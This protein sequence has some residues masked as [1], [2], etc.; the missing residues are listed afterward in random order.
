MQTEACVYGDG[1]QREKR[2]QPEITMIFMLNQA[3]HVVTARQQSW[4]DFSTDMLIK[5]F[6]HFGLIINP[7]QLT[8]LISLWP[9]I[10]DKYMPNRVPQTRLR[11]I[12]PNTIEYIM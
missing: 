4:T 7:V 8:A 3:L 6:G 9:S 10:H 1:K 12:S 2:P 11:V 5:S